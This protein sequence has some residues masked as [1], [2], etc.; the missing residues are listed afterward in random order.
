MA[1][2][3]RPLAVVAAILLP[4]LGVY[5]DRGI[6]APF[7]LAC[8]LTLVAFVPG[9][10]YALWLTVVQPASRADDGVAAAR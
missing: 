2:P 9:M 7:W 5:L 4:P 1:G 6:G 10:L 8:L 3:I